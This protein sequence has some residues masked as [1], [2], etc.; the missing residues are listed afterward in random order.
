MIAMPKQCTIAHRSVC[1]W[2]WNLSKRVQKTRIGT[3]TKTM[4]ETKRLSCAM[5][6]SWLSPEKSA[7][8]S[9]AD[10]TIQRIHERTLA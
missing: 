5:K 10:K 6:R 8:T 9:C 4:I 7:A 1:S 3:G 2:P